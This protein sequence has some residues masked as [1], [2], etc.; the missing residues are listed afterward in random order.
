MRGKDY[1][2][3]K[4]TDDELNCKRCRKASSC[5]ITAASID[6]LISRRIFV[7]RC[8]SGAQE[9]QGYCRR[10]PASSLSYPPGGP[11]S[12]YEDGLD[13]DPEILGIPI[14]GILLYAAVDLTSWRQGFNPAGH[15]GNRE[16]GSGSHTKLTPAFSKF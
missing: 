4:L 5:L 9:P 10:G 16:Y 11:N 3:R 8:F 6:Q 12:V 7:N 15:A 1:F 14:L 2:L 13:V